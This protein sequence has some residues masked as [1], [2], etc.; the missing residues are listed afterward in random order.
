MFMYDKKST[1]L[2]LWLITIFGIVV[3]VGF[4]WIMVYFEKTF[5][6]TSN[7]DVLAHATVGFYGVIGISVAIAFVSKLW[8]NAWIEGV[9]DKEE[10]EDKYEEAEEEI[11]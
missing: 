4:G 7:W 3:S 10:S 9:F 5:E 11:W 2:M 1:L 8:I 6:V